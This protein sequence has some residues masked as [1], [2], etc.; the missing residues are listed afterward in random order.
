M[1]LSKVK[2][3]VETLPVPTP[4]SDE[5][6]VKMAAAAV[7]PSDYSQWR[8]RVQSGS[9]L[10]IEG[11][12]VVVGGNGKVG[13]KV[14]VVNMPVGQGSWSEYVT[15]KADPRN[16]SLYPLPE[17]VA[18][19][20]AASFFVN[21]FTAVGILDTACKSSANNTFVS[22]AAASQL[23]IMMIKLAK[24]IGNITVINVVRREE[25]A[26][27]LRQIGAEHV[28]VAEDTDR[29]SMTALK[30]KMRELECTVC[31]D[32]IA[33]RMTSSLMAIVPNNGTV[34]CY[35]GLNGALDGI[36]PLDLIYSN[37]KLEGWLLNRWLLDGGEAEVG[38]RIHATTSRCVQGL[39]GGW[40]KSI[41]R[42]TSLDRVQL[43]LL[44][45][46]RDGATGTKLRIIL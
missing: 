1:D 11:S 3:D 34:F 39:S 36:S 6:L 43:D 42:N 23:G 19:E 32:A 29:D 24:E 18:V 35:G 2:L 17:S 31:F 38:P 9:P 41:F 22:T 37:K 27:M 45:L 44:S 16:G 15:L 28:V 12:G 10:G 13:T 7:N 14:G 26:E 30:V 33:G 25:Q 5:V 40:S 4:R 46:I 21:P 20:D 8:G